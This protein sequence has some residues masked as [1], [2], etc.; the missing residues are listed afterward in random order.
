MKV[1]ARLLYF[2]DNLPSLWQEGVFPFRQLE[3]FDLVRTSWN[4]KKSRAQGGRTGEHFKLYEK[5]EVGPAKKKRSGKVPTPGRGDTKK[6]A[7]KRTASESR[8]W[9]DKYA[10]N[11]RTTS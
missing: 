2:E 8:P 11:P 1:G 4:Y 3:S 5:L 6:T 10:I 7:G 9:V